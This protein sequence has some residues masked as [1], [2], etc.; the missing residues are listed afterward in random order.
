MLLESQSLLLSAL[1]RGTYGKAAGLVAPRGKRASALT[2]AT[3]EEALCQRRGTKNAT[4]D[5]TGT[6]T[7]DGDVRRVAAEVLNVAL[8]PLKSKNLIKQAVVARMAVLRLLG[9]FR[10]RHEAQ[11]S[12]AIFNAHN[13]HATAGKVLPQVATIVLGLES[14]AMNPY[15]HRQTVGDRGGRRGNAQI[16]AI[17][18]HHVFSPSGTCGLRRPRAELVGFQH[19]LPSLRGLGLTPA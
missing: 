19:A 3:M 2:D 4:A 1:L 9:E 5:G 12:R 17:L 11:G 8:H 18:V 15:H 10:M 16:E 13:D 7:E 6:L 14:A